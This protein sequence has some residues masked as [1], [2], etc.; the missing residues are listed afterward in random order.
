MASLITT[1]GI[2]A[3]SY[4][5]SARANGSSKITASYNTTGNRYGFGRGKGQG[6]SGIVTAI[7]GPLLTISGKNNATYAVDAS[8]ATL[9]K[10]STLSEN[11][12]RI[13][14]VPAAIALSDIKIGDAIMIR[15]EISGNAIKTITI[16]QGKKSARKTTTKTKLAKVSNSKITTQNN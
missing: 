7:A 11:G 3:M 4:P 5:E 16:A 12:V 1:L 10:M 14:G 2:G 9:L 6:A 8:N 15:G 13:P